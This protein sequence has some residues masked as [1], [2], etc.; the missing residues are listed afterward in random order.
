LQYGA[1]NFD[2]PAGVDGF[3][4]CGNH[5][6]LSGVGLSFCAYKSAV[7]ILFD[8]TAAV[9]QQFCLHGSAALVAGGRTFE[10]R[11]DKSAVL[12]IDQA[13]TVKFSADYKQLVLRIDANL[14]ERKFTALTGRTPQAPF[15]FDRALDL[16]SPE[17]RS[18]KQVVLM[19]AELFSD[20]GSAVPP[21]LSAELEQTAV[22]ALLS[23]S[24]HNFSR[25]L[26]EEPGDAAPW[27]VRRIEDYIEAHW[28]TPITVEKLAEI[29]NVGARS[30]FKA[31]RASRG[32]SPMAFAKQVRLRHAR[33]MLLAP[34]AH[35]S[36]V[37][38]AFAC[39][40]SNPG[41]FARDYR[42]AFGE[43]P[44]ATLKRAK[45]LLVS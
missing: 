5:L 28:N 16:G 42:S 26:E 25:F 6:Q 2:Y 34:E 11:P 3:F 40:F 35:T 37:G 12:N 30:V 7:N 22:T 8:E 38:V 9:R 27:Q 31:F 33:V 23:C 10:I 17:G 4:G 24:G 20:A 18:L 1:R 19:M 21:M 39:G 36:A 45:R 41:H 15:V 29:A 13:A 43:L 14:L 32:Y 44:S